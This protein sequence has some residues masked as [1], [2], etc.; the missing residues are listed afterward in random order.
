L[1]NYSDRESDFTELDTQVL[2]VIQENPWVA[3]AWAEKVG[4]TLPVLSDTKH[5]VARAYGI[6]DED[7]YM[8][9]R[10]TITVD[11]EGVIRA[12]HQDR[13]AIDVDPALEA[14]RVL[15]RVD[16]TSGR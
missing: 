10:T 3:K 11:Q 13:E 14:C 4:T 6:F 16:S 15:Q 9:R 8:A 12:I 1:T 5:E 7:K 2:G